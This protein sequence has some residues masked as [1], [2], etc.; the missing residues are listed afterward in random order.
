MSLIARCP[1]LLDIRGLLNNKAK[2]VSKITSVRAK[3]EKKESNLVGNSVRNTSCQFGR[4][5]KASD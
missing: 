5:P 4:L 3:K 2:N 1:P